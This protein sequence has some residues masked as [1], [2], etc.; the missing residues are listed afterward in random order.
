M[1]SLKKTGHLDYDKD[2][3]D[4]DV[5]GSDDDGGDDDDGDDDDDDDGGDDDDDDDDDDEHISCAFKNSS[6]ISCSPSMRNLRDLI[7]WR[8]C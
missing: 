2:D 5:G 4:D 1:G 6:Y 3:D 8:W 7:G